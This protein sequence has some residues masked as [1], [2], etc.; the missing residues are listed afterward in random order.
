[1]YTLRESEA[2]CSL[3]RIPVCDDSMKPAG[4]PGAH[5]NVVV[6]VEVDDIAEVVVLVPAG[7]AAVAG[8]LVRPEAVV[9]CAQMQPL[10]QQVKYDSNSHGY[11]QRQL[12]D[13]SWEA[14]HGC[15]YYCSASAC[16]TAV[17]QYATDQFSM[18]AAGAI[19]KG[20]CL[21]CR[22]A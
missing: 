13:S 1:M 10:Q 22:Q 18:A 3:S 2:Q 20:I 4:E 16:A 6:I 5:G 12:K 8:P 9:G 7:A 14:V 19:D 17:H 15:K 21:S 11:S